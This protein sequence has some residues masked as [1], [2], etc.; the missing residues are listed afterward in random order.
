MYSTNYLTILLLNTLLFTVAACSRDE[1]IVAASASR[2]ADPEV[3]A[4][5]AESPRSAAPEGGL[6]G[7]TWRLVRIMSMDDT[8]DLP[9]DPGLYSLQFGRDGS[10]TLTADCNTGTGSWSSDSPGQLRFGDITA[11]GAECAPGSMH[12][13]YV[14]QFQWVRSYVLENGHLFLATMADGSIIEFE[15]TT[16]SNR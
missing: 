4:A 14:S 11:T 6:D 1:S 16:D 13:K 8:T 3:A 5:T 15:P 10:M 9:G 7:T 12:R 2:A